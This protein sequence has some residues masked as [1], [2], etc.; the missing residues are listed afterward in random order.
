MSGPH[1]P[2]NR[3]SAHI[4]V[5]RFLASSLPGL[6]QVALPNGTVFSVATR[7]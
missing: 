7:Q 4:E 1:R 5:R 3:F 2:A 6:T